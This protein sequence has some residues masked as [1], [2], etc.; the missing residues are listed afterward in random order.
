MLRLSLALALAL[1]ACAAMPAHATDTTGVPGRGGDGKCPVNIP[2]DPDC[3]REGFQYR[4]SGRI[5][6]DKAKASR[7]VFPGRRVGGGASG[8]G[9]VIKPVRLKSSDRDQF[10]G[11]RRGSG[12]PVP[13]APKA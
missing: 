11:D 1:S 10:P 9:P 4:G 7:D 12:G 5:D 6:P 3:C 2:T 8:D 13:R